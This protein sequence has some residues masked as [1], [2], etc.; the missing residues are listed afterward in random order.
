MNHAIT[1]LWVSLGT[2]LGGVL[3]FGADRLIPT[4]IGITWSTLAVNTL[5]SILIG[6]IAARATDPSSRLTNA[7]LH[8]FLVPGFC[9]GLTTFS[10]FSHQTLILLRA[11]DLS[12][13]LLNVTAT[14][15]LMVAGAA[16]GLAAGANA[17]K[18]R[19]G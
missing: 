8:A 12:G 17:R 18:H 1:T 7:Q 9:A 6:W 10:V 11:G 15:V 14:L 3:R 13:A 19:G 16:L 2:A 5:G 4:G